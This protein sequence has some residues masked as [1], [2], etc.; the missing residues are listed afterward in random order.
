MLIAQAINHS[1]VIVSSDQAFDHYEIQRV[2]S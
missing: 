2:W 1:L